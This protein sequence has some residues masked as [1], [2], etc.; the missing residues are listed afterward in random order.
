M[1][2]RRERKREGK[3]DKGFVGIVQHIF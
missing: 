2:R 1:L 3:V